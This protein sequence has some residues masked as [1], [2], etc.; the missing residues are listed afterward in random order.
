MDIRACT[1]EDVKDICEIYNHYI[2]NT[3]IT[4]EENPVDHNEMLK[5]MESY[6]Q[7]YPW[8]VCE[9]DCKVIGYA[10]ATKWKERSAYKHSVE[11][12]VYLKHSLAGKGYG[13][14]LYAALLDALY[15]M[16][17]HLILA[18]IA[19]PNDASIKLHES[20]GFKKVAHFSEVGRKFDNWI[21]VGYW[22]KKNPNFL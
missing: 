8:Y 16:N 18:G 2:E 13:T 17:C 14:A 11:V 20:Y 22:E 9:V 10:Y 3:T 6:T 7:T 1:P 15:K 19:L 21:D 12:T 4:F 5:R